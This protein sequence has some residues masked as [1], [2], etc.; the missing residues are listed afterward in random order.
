MWKILQKEIF[1]SMKTTGAFGILS[2]H[3]TNDIVNNI[4]RSNIK[5]VVE[6]WPWRGN[7]TQAILDKLPQDGTLTCFEINEKDFKPHL[8]RI[9]DSRLTVHYSSCEDLNQYFQ[10]SSLDLIVSTIPFSLL[11]KPS[12]DSILLQSF[13]CLRPGGIFTTGQYSTFIKPHL[14]ALFGSVTTKWSFFNIPP[15]CIH[16][17]TKQ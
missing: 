8:N 5:S 15:V 4:D 12:R 14:E 10:A 16:K 7:I 2:K 13:E 17:V 1:T 11:T 9:N 3:T 6:F